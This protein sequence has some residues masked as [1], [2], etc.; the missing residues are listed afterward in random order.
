MPVRA[1]TY[2][3]GARAAAGFSPDAS[4][5][6]FVKVDQRGDQNPVFCLLYSY[7]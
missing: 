2:Q 3:D 4:G 1:E 7:K 6:Y 5:T